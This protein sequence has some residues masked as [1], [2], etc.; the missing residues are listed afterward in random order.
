[1]LLCCGLAV[2]A[3]A[4]TVFNSPY[5]GQNPGNASDQDGVIG[6]NGQFDLQSVAFTNL[7]TTNF[8]VQI[9]FNYDYGDTTLSPFKIDGI[10]LS[11]GD[12]LFSSGNQNWGVALDSHTGFTQ[13]DLYSVTSFSTAKTVLGNP[14]GASYRP[15]DDVWMDENGGQILAGLGTST[16]KSIGGD[17]VQT[18]LSFTPSAG[19]I[20][21]LESGNLTFQFSS[22]TCSN[23]YI[24]G[25]LTADVISTVPEP[26]GF[27]LLG[28]GLIALSVIPRLRR[29]RK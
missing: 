10:T 20:S 3:P 17:E 19:L 14:Q 7:S 28:S 1:M 8:T 16:T 24:T 15:N 4:A 21:A 23:D 18:T 12:L 5:D 13:G 6:A 29:R 2:T 27:V 9:D 26:T 25:K 22:A 11:A